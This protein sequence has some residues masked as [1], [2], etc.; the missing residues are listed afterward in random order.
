MQAR[1]DILFFVFMAVSY[2]IGSIP[3]GVIISKAFGGKDPRTV[4]SR[5]IGATNVGRSAGKVAGILTLIGDFLKGAVPAYVA[6]GLTDN[7]WLVTAT[8]L[9]AFLGHL[10]PIFLGF[11][12]GKGV[13]TAAGVMAMVS[14]VATI[15]S[16]VVF[17]VALAAKRYVSLGSMLAAASL[18]VALS[19]FTKGKPYLPLGVLIA[20]LVILKHKDNIKRLA[21]GTETRLF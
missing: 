21:E 20:V 6:M 2:L 15:I 8:G 19:F 1:P 12:G 16:A 3:T 4:G 17:A 7:T 10:F 5:N 9:S 18:P 11:R 14:P 13:A